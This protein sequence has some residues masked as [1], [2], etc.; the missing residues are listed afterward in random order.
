MN[1]SETKPQPMRPAGGEKANDH[2]ADLIPYVAPSEGCSTVWL[3][4]GWCDDVVA[5]D[6]PTDAQPGRI[7]TV[8]HY[9]V[10]PEVYAWV[11]GKLVAV[12]DKAYAPLPKPGT[13]DP[14]ALRQ[15][16]DD[17]ADQRALRAALAAATDRWLP[18]AA[19]AERVYGA[20]AIAAAQPTLPRAGRVPEVG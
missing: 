5:I 10:T 2:T 8:L 14:D 19:W 15:P 16:S 12:E 13:V 1:A 17:A 3:P 11:R 20:E 9:R 18:V 4:D 6:F 7:V